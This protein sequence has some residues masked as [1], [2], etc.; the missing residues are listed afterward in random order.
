M[1]DLLLSTDCVLLLPFISILLHE[2]H[3]LKPQFDI[4]VVDD[5]YW[6]HFLQCSNIFLT[7]EHDICL[8]KKNLCLFPSGNWT[9]F[10]VSQ[11]CY[12]SQKWQMHN[13]ASMFLGLSLLW[14]MYY[15]ETIV[16]H[17]AGDFGL[18]KTLNQE[19]LASSVSDTHPTR[20]LMQFASA[21]W[22]KDFRSCS[23]HSC[24][25]SVCRQWWHDAFI[26]LWFWM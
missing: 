23:S 10:A 6:M 20:L 19:D 9:L 24:A 22:S 25:L 2:L 5:A 3:S 7:K 14:W 17:M 1:V 15:N 8:G 21:Q 11:S 12:A 4:S 18:A 13:I 26:Y 16:W